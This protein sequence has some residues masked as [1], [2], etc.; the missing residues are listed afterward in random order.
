VESMNG[1]QILGLDHIDLSVRDLARSR[2]FYDSVLTVLGFHRITDD[3]TIV[4]RGPHLEIGIRAATSG[5]E[6]KPHDRYDVGLHHLA[7]RAQSRADVDRFHGFLVQEGI[8]VLDPPTDYPEYSAPY[9][10]VFFVD[11]DG[12]KLELAYRRS[13]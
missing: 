9:Y 7:F 3:G 8:D 13:A 5:D 4:W 6:G 1:V 2:A 10:A 12:I 11:P